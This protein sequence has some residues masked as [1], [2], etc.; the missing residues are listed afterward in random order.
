MLTNELA[1]EYLDG[2]QLRFART[3]EPK[4]NDALTLAVSALRKEQ[5][6]MLTAAELALNLYKVNSEQEGESPPL[7]WSEVVEAERQRWEAIAR[8]ALTCL[9]NAKPQ[10][11]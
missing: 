4:L 9:N 6:I 10:G 8:A 5:S 7:Q 11:E 3:I 2:I 1:A